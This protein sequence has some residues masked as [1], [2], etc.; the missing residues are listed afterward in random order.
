MKTLSLIYNIANRLQAFNPQANQSVQPTWQI[1]L[2]LIF[3]LSILEVIFRFWVSE[4]E[5]VLNHSL[6]FEMNTLFT[7]FVMEKIMP[8]FGKVKIVCKC[9]LMIQ[10]IIYYSNK[11]VIKLYRLWK[12]LIALLDRKTQ[13]SAMILHVLAGKGI[14]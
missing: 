6:N 2:F 13:F 11:R 8:I 1:R 12:V 14:L 5:N 10:T 3:V 9:H 4:H 7:F